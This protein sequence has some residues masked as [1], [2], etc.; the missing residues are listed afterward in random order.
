[1]AIID[2]LERIFKGRSSYV[3]SETLDPVVVRHCLAILDGEKDAIL[4][5]AD[6]LLELQTPS[7][8]QVRELYTKQYYSAPRDES[9]AVL[10]ALPDKMGWLLACD[11][12]EHFMKENYAERGEPFKDS[13]HFQVIQACRAW[14]AG[15]I[16]GHQWG[17]A[18]K[19]APPYYRMWGTKSSGSQAACE[20]LGGILAFSAT[21]GREPAWQHRRI[22]EYLLG[23]GAPDLSEEKELR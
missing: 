15:E 21:G 20:A 13:Q 16:S 18:L 11:F 14:I 9:L 2:W 8:N 6:R 23:S 4:L 7:A 5:L 22:R 1:M 10:L 19:D 12:A 17:K 3:K